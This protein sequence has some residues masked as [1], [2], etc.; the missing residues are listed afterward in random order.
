[1]T[2]PATIEAPCPQRVAIIGGRGQMGALFVQRSLDLGLDVRSLGRPLDHDKLARELADAELV[3]LSVPVPAMAETAARCAAHM[4]PPQIL[5]DVASVKALPLADMVRAYA[6]PVAGTHPLFGPVPPEGAQV[7]VM[8]GRPES[9]AD[10]EAVAAVSAWFQAMGFPCFA[11]TPTEHDSAVAMIQ[12]LNFVTTVSYLAALAK[13]EHIERFLTPSFQRR[14][15]AAQ[16]MLTQDAELFTTLFETNPSS[17]D[18]VRRYRNFLHVAAGGDMDLLVEQAAWWW[19]DQ[20][21]QDD[22]T[23]RDG[24]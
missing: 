23:T 5:A 21:D 1:M 17:Q 22:T 3:V 6:G 9:L 14:L 2:D 12:G 16:K 15:E 19:R 4:Q 8:P 18:A 7:A 20:P 11:S 24:T 10:A 13:Q